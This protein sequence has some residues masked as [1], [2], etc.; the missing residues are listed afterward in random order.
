MSGKNFVQAAVAGKQR[1]LVAEDPE[2]PFQDL[3]KLLAF[4]HELAGHRIERHLPERGEEIQAG[5]KDRVGLDQFR[6]RRADEQP[7]KVVLLPFG[8]RHELVQDLRY[9]T[10]LIR[11][12]DFQQGE[13]C[14]AS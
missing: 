14:P 9:G 11:H 7:R 3:V 6:H 5:R 10:R 8:Q 2:L 1:V 13:R 4:L 12:R